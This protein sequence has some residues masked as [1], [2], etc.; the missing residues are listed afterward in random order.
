MSRQTAS[1]A[2]ALHGNSLSQ[3]ESKPASPKVASADRPPQTLN[4][5][6]V[7][8]ISFI[9]C[10][11]SILTSAIDLCTPS[12]AVSPRKLEAKEIWHLQHISSLYA[13]QDRHTGNLNAT[14]TIKLIHLSI[15][16][17]LRVHLSAVCLHVFDQV[18]Q[19]KYL[20]ISASGNA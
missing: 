20:C 19:D 4:H 3:A 13:L 16:L 14:N 10:N 18:R 17:D 6:R 1:N 7:H 15:A 11:S 2:T 8:H 12:S 9:Q 5:P